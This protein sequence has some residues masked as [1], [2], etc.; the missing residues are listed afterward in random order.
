M[1]MVTGKASLTMVGLQGDDE[2]KRIGR[3]IASP[4]PDWESNGWWVGG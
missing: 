4:L 3:C 1:Y 2:G